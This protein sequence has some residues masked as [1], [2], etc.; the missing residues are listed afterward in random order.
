MKQK[1]SPWDSGFQASS[2]PCWSKRS[3][4]ISI[5]D[6]PPPFPSFYVCFLLCSTPRLQQEEYTLWG[7]SV[8]DKLP[9]A[10]HS[11]YC[12]DPTLYGILSVPALF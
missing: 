4:V 9:P 3:E 5:S 6:S 1:D 12:R 11:S 10:M 2:K 8:Q 7:L